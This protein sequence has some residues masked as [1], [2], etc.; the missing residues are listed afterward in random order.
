[1]GVLGGIL[2]N[3]P[4]TDNYDIDLGTYMV[5]DWYRQTAYQVDSITEANLQ[6]G[7]GPPPADNILVNGTNTNKFGGGKHS[8]VSLTKG[9]RYLLRLINPSVDNAIR[10]KLDGHPFE[11]VTSDLVPIYPITTDWLLL[12]IG[13][14]YNVIIE[15]NQTVDNYWFRAV[16][17]TACNST[18]ANTDGFSAIFRYSGAPSTNP[19]NTTAT[20]RPV[21]CN[22]PSPL[23]PYFPNTIPSA[24]FT[25]QAAHLP[26]SVGNSSVVTNE[27]NLVLWGINFTAIDVD[28]EKP[29]L[30]YVQQGNTSY[31]RT[32]NLIELPTPDTWTYWIIQEDPANGPAIP[33]PMHLHGHDFFI[34]GQ[35]GNDIFSNSSISSLTFSNPPRRDTAILPAGGWLV[36]AFQ[37]DNPGAWLMHCHIVSFSYLFP[38]AP[39]NPN[40]IQAWHIGEG[41]GVQFLESK[42]SLPAYPADYNQT[43]AAWTDYYDNPKYFQDD[44]GL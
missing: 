9:N 36:I 22:E 23:V 15:A 2:I 11:I 38:S 33:H 7:L 35:K 17:E 43:C 20:A 41:L 16:A 31:P 30:T 27:Q 3:G 19:A 4:A 37:T 1:M 40:P 44:S 6:R 13:Q 34:L 10:V 24:N 18:N 14:R 12:G 42:S 28:W 29:I 5:N 39:F 32:E 26:V 25:T 21:D 8:I